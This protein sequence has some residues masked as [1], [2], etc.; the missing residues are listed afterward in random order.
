MGRRIA[1]GREDAEI[2][3]AAWPP[4]TPGGNL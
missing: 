4:G 2:S 1:P 3:V